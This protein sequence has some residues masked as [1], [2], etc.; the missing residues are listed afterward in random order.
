MRYTTIIDIT[1]LSRI[2][3]N[4]NA[5]LV[6]LH[7]CLRSG[8][9]AED[10]DHIK[11]SIRRLAMAIGLTV[12]ATRHAL[13][14]LER[15]R[16]ISRTEDGWNVKKWV[17]ESFP[18]KEAVRKKTE[19]QLER[20]HHAEEARKKWHQDLHQAVVTST[21]EELEEW[22]RKLQEAPHGRNVYHKG[23]RLWNCEEHVEW[24]RNIIRSV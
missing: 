19:A 11:I 14:Q 22:L 18:S 24:L 15:D 21:R 12:S 4:T 13:A 1:E 3:R 8:Y 16:L 6:Y 17:V 20:E 2:Y 9:H 7:M 10:K 23:A 5:R